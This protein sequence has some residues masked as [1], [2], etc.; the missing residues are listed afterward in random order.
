MIIA[1]FDPGET[2]GLA[3]VEG[4]CTGVVLAQDSD[5]DTLWFLLTET[6]RKLENPLDLREIVIE[7]F[8]LYP[9]A[10]RNQGFSRPASPEMIGRLAEKI[11]EIDASIVFQA[12]SMRMRITDQVLKASGLY[13]KG[14]PHANDALRHALYRLWFGHGYQY[15]PKVQD[16]FLGIARNSVKDV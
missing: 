9:G 7:D 16:L 2:T 8:R 13:T 12:P 10:I 4:P 14:I 5:I 11:K 3:I 1:A 15:A 6:T